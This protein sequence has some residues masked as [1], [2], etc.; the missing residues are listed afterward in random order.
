MMNR[1][2]Q[3]VMQAGRAGFT[4]LELLVV[5]AI[6][7]IVAGGII[8]A[9]D[10]LEEKSGH[11][12]ATFNIGALDSSIRVFATLNGSHPNQYDSLLYSDDGTGTDGV[13]LNI[14][15]EELLEVTGGFAL[16]A[17]ALDAL[18]EAGID[19]LR[20]V[21]GTLSYDNTATQ[22]SIPNRVFDNPTRGYGLGV[23]LAVGSVVPAVAGLGI[24]NFAGDELFDSTLAQNIA[25]GLDPTRAHVLVVVGIGNNCTLVKSGS[26]TAIGGISEAPFEHGEPQLYHRLLAVYHLGSST[27]ATL[28]NVAYFSKARFLGVLSS[29]GEPYDVEYAEFQGGN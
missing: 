18:Q 3:R 21:S 12:V 9:Y 29:H 22:P 17:P 16:T 11:G 26:S 7:A 4:L 14:L 8:V 27:D 6:L 2:R 19:T 1:Q 10:G 15:D 28:A 23:P 5:V 25:A 24:D 20:Y 13:A